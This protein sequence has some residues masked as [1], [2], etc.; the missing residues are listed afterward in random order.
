MTPN[1]TCTSCGK[2]IHWIVLPASGKRMPIDPW[3]LARPK[4]GYKPGMV[5]FNSATDQGKV[6]SKADVDGPLDEWLLRHPVTVHTSHFVT[7]PEAAK[8][9][10][11]K[12][13]VT[14]T[15]G[16]GNPHAPLPD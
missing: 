7:C 13:K 11:R 16:D 3:A 6:L 9:R 10:K 4:A 5:A 2:E 12:P 1:G 8:H 14:A 15:D